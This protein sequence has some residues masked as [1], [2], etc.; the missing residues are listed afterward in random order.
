[1]SGEFA[2]GSYVVYGKMGVCRLMDKQTM[3]F[4]GDSGEYYVLLPVSDDRSSVYV[5]CDN[6]NLMARLRTL[7]TPQQIGDILAGV[8]DSRLEWIDDRTERQATFRG[9]MGADDRLQLMR[10]IRCLYCKKQEKIAAGK[11][12]SAMDE[13]YL[14]DAI[15]LVEEEFA[16]ALDIPRNRVSEYIRSRIEGE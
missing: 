12:L 5:P 1:M 9:I 3:S 4:G 14:Q 7:L 2:K 6:P 10:L 15:R 13:G 8:D 16:I 11:R